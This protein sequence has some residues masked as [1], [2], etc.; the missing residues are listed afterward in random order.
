MAD[1][2]VPHYWCPICN[3][4]LDVG[5]PEAVSDEHVLR[6][7]G[8]GSWPNANVEMVVRVLARVV[9]RLMMKGEGDA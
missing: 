9:H 3:I 8:D 6:H 1:G 5:L 2:R 4:G 7:F